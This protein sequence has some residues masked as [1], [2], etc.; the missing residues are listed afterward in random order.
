VC[1]TVSSDR[2]ASVAIK[3]EKAL[4]LIVASSDIH[5][6]IPLGQTLKALQPELLNTSAIAPTFAPS[7]PT[8]A[9]ASSQK[10]DLLKH[11]LS[12]NVHEVRVAF[13]SP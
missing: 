11:A 5:A 13:R 12:H 7:A 10:I 6:L 4:A 2:R 1:K 3:C 9:A 8:P